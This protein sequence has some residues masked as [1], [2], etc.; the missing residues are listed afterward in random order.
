M[1]K[2]MTKQNIQTKNRIMDYQ[3]EDYD[4]QQGNRVI[5][6]IPVSGLIYKSNPLI[7]RNTLVRIIIYYILFYCAYMQ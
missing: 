7:I 3:N 5:D 6:T 4:L 2:V 1:I